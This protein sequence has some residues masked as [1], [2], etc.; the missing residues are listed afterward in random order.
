MVNEDLTP[1]G[2]RVETF[3]Y[4]HLLH[5]LE[6]MS[7]LKRSWTSTELLTRI[8]QWIRVRPF[9]MLLA[10]ASNT[11]LTSFNG[12]LQCPIKQVYRNS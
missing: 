9:T 4:D 11:N 1:I 6:A 8:A 12:R 3:L 2:H 10:V 5:W 7:L